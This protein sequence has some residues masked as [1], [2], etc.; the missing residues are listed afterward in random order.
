MS[1]HPNFIVAEYFGGPLDGKTQTLEWGTRYVVINEVDHPG[2]VEPEG[3]M[4]ELPIYKT[5]YERLDGTFTYV[6]MGRVKP[7]PEERT[8]PPPP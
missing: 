4:L 2:W 5:Y 1:I 8:S 7:R 3:E 6:Y